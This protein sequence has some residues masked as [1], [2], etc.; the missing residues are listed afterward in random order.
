MFVEFNLPN[1]QFVHRL[2]AQYD[3]MLPC[4]HQC[5]GGSMPFILYQ[6]PP[7]GC[8]C[9]LFQSLI[10]SWKL[11]VVCCCMRLHSVEC[12]WLLEIIGNRSVDIIRSKYVYGSCCN[13]GYLSL[14]PSFSL[15]D[16]STYIVC[17]INGQL[18]PTIVCFLLKFVC[19]R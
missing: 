13:H 14:I 16:L 11:N 3:S 7:H 10:Y 1:I 4:L 5:Q 19:L 17:A 9:L 8:I 18:S 6:L 12:I 15:L 2:I